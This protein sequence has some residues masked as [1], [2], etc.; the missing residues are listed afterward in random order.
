M[1]TFTLV[2]CADPY[3]FEAIDTMLNLGEAIL[4]KG[5]QI[6]GIF[7]YGNG[8]Y[9]INRDINVG[10]AIRNLPKRLEDFMKKYNLSI[11]ACST[12]INFTGLNRE[13]LIPGVCQEGLGGL[14]EWIAMSDRVLIF[15]PGGA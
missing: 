13:K 6:I 3:K 10:S 14:A 9:N 7:F 11:N 2:V 1:V 5:H 4:K 8:V 15:G 12:W